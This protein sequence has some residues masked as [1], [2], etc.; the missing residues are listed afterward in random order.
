M[1]RVACLTSEGKLILVPADELHYGV[2]VYG[3]LIENER[4]LLRRNLETGLWEPP[5]GHLVG[6]Q[7]PRQ[8]VRSLFRAQTGLVCEP[9]RRLLLESQHRID[10]RGEAWELAVIHYALQRNPGSTLTLPPDERIQ[11]VWIQLRE[12]K[13]EE[14][15]AGYEAI[16]VATQHNGTLATL[17]P[18]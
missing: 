10:I 9:E 7:A 17:R 13:R 18:E 4:V 1:D 6:R 14:M 5:G 12:L 2:V 16:L 11:P 3:I 15:A 8:G